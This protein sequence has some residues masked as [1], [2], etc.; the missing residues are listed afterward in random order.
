MSKSEVR[1][2]NGRPVL[3]VDNQK[4]LP[5]LYGLSDIPGSNSNTAQA[6][7]NIANFADAGIHIVQVDCGIH[8]GWHK[9]TPFDPEALIAEIGSV[10]EVNEKAKVI[11]RL[12]VNPPY[13]WM[14]DNPDECVV[15]RTPEGD[16]DGVDD[17]ENSDRLIRNDAKGHMRV[18]LASVKWLEETSEKLEAFL[19]ALEGTHEG[20]A[21]IGVQIACGKNGEWHPWGCDVGKPAKARFE[22]YLR[23]KYGTNEALQRAWHRPDVT[24]ET[25]AYRPELS[26]PTDD[27][28]FHDPRLAQDTIDSQYCN[29]LIV[30]EAILHFCRLVK[31][32]SPE[33][34]AGSFYGYY[35]GIGTPENGGHMCTDLVFADGSVDFLGGPFS[36]SAASRGMDG[37][38]LQRTLPESQ[39]LRGMLWLTE[40]DQRPFGIEK[41]PGGDPALFAENVASLRQCTLSPI[42]AG[43]GF[44]YYDHRVVPTMAIYAGSAGTAAAS[45]YRK[46]GWWDTPEMMAEIRTFREAVDKIEARP[47]KGAAD[48][49]L[50]FDQD[51]YYY[52]NRESANPALAYDPHVAVTPQMMLKSGAVYDMIWL[53]ELEVAELDRYKCVIFVNCTAVTP[54]MSDKIRRLT[55]GKLRV[56][57]CRHGYCD[58]ESLSAEHTSAAVGIQ[59]ARSD[60][61]ALTVHD[62]KIAMEQGMYP[63]L[64]VTDADAKVLF[65]YDNGDAAAAVKGSDVYI[66]LPYL[67]EKLWKQIMEMAGVH[68]WCDSGEPVMAGGG[69]VTVCCQRAGTRV[70]TLPDGREIPITTNGYETVVY[71]MESGGRIL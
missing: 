45:I 39:R 59:V 19:R 25:A 71:D 37:A 21:L 40:M 52:T 55:E 35:L 28:D 32:V 53:S 68:N 1:Q 14:R 61:Q 13:W 6:Q 65:R 57:L 62:K 50:V 51:S 36:Y 41:Q 7:K 67:T 60:A 47:Y 63:V 9:V 44:W 16:L 10:L 27:G 64:R 34:L 18:S 17:G 66:H 3:Y 2:E 48:V 49:L 24:F 4:M 30:A 42:M 26:R 22:R 20:D 12:H 31:R 46:K 33:R 54:Q 56:F 23:E 15:Y 69:F 43:Q 29:Q 38:A 11:M 58:C 70:L 5:I 8:L